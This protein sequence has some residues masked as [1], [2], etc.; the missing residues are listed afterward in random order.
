MKKADW[1]NHV[2]HI[3]VHA[4]HC[5]VQWGEDFRPNYY[6]ID[7]LRALFPRS[8]PMIIAV[9]MAATLTMQ[10][11]IVRLLDMQNVSIVQGQTYR[12]NIKYA[13]KRCPPHAGKHNSVEESYTSIFLPYLQELKEQGKSFPKTVVYAYLKWCGFG[14]EQGVKLLSNGDIKS[15]G[16]K[17]VSQYHAPLLP[18]VMFAFVDHWFR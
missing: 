7:T 5:V 16:V 13:A 8:H 4:A 1:N 2:R 10:K 3:F 18:E 9:T 11:D 6:N 15:T 17:E 14:D 12:V